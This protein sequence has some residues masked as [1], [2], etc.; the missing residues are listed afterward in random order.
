MYG[1]VKKNYIK[2]KRTGEPLI[3]NERPGQIAVRLLIYKHVF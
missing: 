1:S 3:V 2:I